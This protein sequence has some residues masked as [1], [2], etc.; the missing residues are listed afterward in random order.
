MEP[1]STEQRARHPLDPLLA[2]VYT[3]NW[4]A[5][6][7]VVIFVLAVL[8]RMVD[9]GTR[10]MSH[11]ES[12]HVKFAYDLYQNGIFSHTPLMHGPLLFHMTAF[13]YLLFGDNDFTGRLYAALVGIV[14]VMMPILFRR[15]LGRTGALLAS[16]L[17]LISPLLMYYSRYI[18]HDLPVILF[19]LIML[20]AIFQ[21][22]DGPEGV[23]RKP[24][25]LILM[26]AAMSLMLASKEVA[27]IY[28]AIFGSFLTLFWLIRL[29]QQYLRW[30]NGQTLLGLFS[31]GIILGIVAALIL[32]CILW[33]VPPQDYDADGVPNTTDN[34]INVANGTQLD[35]NA[36][37]IGNDCALDPGPNLAGR[38]VT[39]IV[40]IVAILGVTLLGT[41]VW[42]RRK[43]VLGFPWR[44]VL[45]IVLLGVLTCVIFVGLEGV[46]HVNPQL[47]TPVD[48]NATNGAVTAITNNLPIVL[49][50]VVGAVIVGL[51]VLARA[52]GLWEELKRFP[53]FDVLVL[54]GTLILP[55]LTAFL[56]ASTGAKPTDYSTAGI[57]RAVLAL[58]PFAAVAITV[59]LVWNWRVWLVAT[60]V[61]MAI[62]AFFFTTMFTNG[63]GLAS[64][65]IGS[66]GYWIEQ[67]GERRGNQPQYYYVLLMV[68]F[69]EFL[70]LIG[71]SLAGVFGLR[72]LWN[73]VYAQRALNAEAALAEAEATGAEADAAAADGAVVETV[74]VAEPDAIEVAVQEAGERVRSRGTDWLERV[75]FM[76][77]VGYWAVVNLVAYTFAGEKMP[78]LTTHL[79]VPLGLAAAWFGGQIIDGLSWEKVRSDGWKLLILIPLFLV[80]LAQI[81]RLPL[82]GRGPFQG[83]TQFELEQT[84]AWLAA[85]V[86]GVAVLYVI[87]RAIRRIRWNQFWRL[88]AVSAGILLALVTT[89]S[90]LM[91][92]FINYDLPTEFL[93]YAHAGPAHRTVMEM[94]TEISQRTTDGMNLRIAY[95][96]RM[97]WPGSW[98]FRLFPNAVYFGASPSVQVLDDAAAVIVGSDHRA[99]VE[100]LLGDRYYH[101]Q[102]IRMWW[103]MQDY[104]NLTAKRIDN[105]FD[106]SDNPTSAELRRGLWEIWWYRDYTTYG[107]ATGENFDLKDWPV[108]NIMD[109]YIRKDVA[110]QVWDL[111]VGAEV[112]NEYDTPLADL[113]TPRAASLVIGGQ[114]GAAPGQFNHPRDVAVG[115]DGTVYVADSL[116]HRIQA[117]DSDGNFLRQW[118]SFEVG[119]NGQA[120]GGHFNQPWGIS[121]GPDGNVYVADTWN[122]RIQVFTSDGQFIRAWGQIGQLDTA[123]SPTDFWGP[124]AVA[125][126]ADGLVYVADTGN[127]RIRVFTADGELVRSI[128]SSGS[129]AGQLNE[130]VGLAIHSDGRVFVAD[131]WNRRIQVF[132]PFGQYL[133]SW[134]VSAWYGDQGN[135][136]Y[137]AL[138]EAR[139]Q[140]YVTDPDAGRVLVYDLNGTLLGSFG[141]VGALDTPLNATQFNV[142]GGIGIGPDGSVF[143]S[144]AGAARLLRFD[145]WNEIAVQP[146]PEVGQ[147]VLTEQVTEEPTEEV[148]A[149]VTEEVTDEVVEPT[150]AGQAGDGTPA[151]T[152]EPLSPTDDR[153][154]GCPADADHHGDRRRG[155]A[156][157]PIETKARWV[158]AGLF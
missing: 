100:P 21:Y 9:L 62:F 115:Q 148:I 108:N 120:A 59:G 124:R 102:F 112:I 137:I 155:L 78:W 90:A 30:R 20:Y 57:A 146:L 145:P 39:W 157:D 70:P 113:W 63:Q 114:E 2:R 67:Q 79:T 22:V 54:M 121:V 133:T 8:T 123:V 52:L 82:V 80:A 122:H 5:I 86:V 89:R 53:V 98:Y 40:G 93:V 106:F 135:R 84:N 45:L 48:P 85:L 46:T 51:A 131:T 7:Y 14:V 13:F 28:I 134:V 149:P 23:R 132:N 73:H 95:D 75:P 138:D 41:A 3:L 126:G 101:Y 58:I 15:W 42:A 38:L 17:F 111:G 71:A 81:I 116:N 142:I 49:A 92:S 128:G 33:I 99:Q 47:A 37:G 151:V 50:W 118:G 32:I 91:A 154:G 76:M 77:F 104:F 88:A 26:A 61:F 11:D 69:Y 140:L 29:G 87:A 139:G 35:D 24:R 74:I 10:V 25:W 119:E 72:R 44:E 127:K 103:P 68:P 117:F 1:V 129:A 55:W 66:L 36:D 12:L 27:F 18:R 34:C 147:P 144:D 158:P 6:A 96:D 83:L 97:S 152:E 141:Q 156:P 153:R 125:V 60:G 19:A 109:L 143:I 64:G 43:G 110:A 136:P 105:V 65:M 56:I 16:I 150:I 31:A 94:L 4:E 107:Q 130:P